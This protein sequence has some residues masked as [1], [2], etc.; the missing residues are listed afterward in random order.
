MDC[1]GLDLDKETRCRHY[2]TA[3]DI[4]ALKC[5]TCQ[6]YYACYICHDSLESHSF[7]ASSKAE[8]YPVLCGACRKV[9]SRLAYEKGYCPYCSKPFNPKCSAH[10]AIYFS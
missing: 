5:Q 7:K 10:K 1:F 2:H 4:A 8:A 3:R 9:M 6:K